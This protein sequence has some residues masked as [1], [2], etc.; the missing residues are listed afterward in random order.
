MDSRLPSSTRPGFVRQASGVIVE[1]E[2]GEGVNVGAGEEVT[3]GE[4]RVSVGAGWFLGEQA[5]SPTKSKNNLAIRVA[6][7]WVIIYAL[8]PGRLARPRC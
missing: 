8:Y 6:A 7:G 5:K 4:G 1:V 3:V 2:T